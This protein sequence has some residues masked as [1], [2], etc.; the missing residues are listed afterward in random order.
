M[1]S[2]AEL[3]NRYANHNRLMVNSN[4]KLIYTHQGAKGGLT[5]YEVIG[6]SDKQTFTL[7]HIPV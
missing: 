5:A 6:V 2:N 4:G 7:K 1:E 3:E